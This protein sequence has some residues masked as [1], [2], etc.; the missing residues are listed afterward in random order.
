MRLRI[1]NTFALLL[2]V[3]AVSVASALAQS[4][5]QAPAQPA[6]AAGKSLRAEL[7]LSYSYLT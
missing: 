6:P 3:A 2:T 1:K 5:D 4:P 7:A